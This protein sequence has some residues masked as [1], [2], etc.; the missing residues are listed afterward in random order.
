M[1]RPDVV[2]AMR[3]TGNNGGQHHNASAVLSHEAY[4]LAGDATKYPEQLKALRP[5]QPKKFY[6]STGFGPDTDPRR[7]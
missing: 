7:G 4:K 6:Y 5:W 1:I 2:F 3:P